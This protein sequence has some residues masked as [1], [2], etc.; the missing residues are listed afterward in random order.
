VRR[1]ERRRRCRDLF[2]APGRFPQGVVGG[3]SRCKA[4]QESL[5]RSNYQ[6]YSP[7]TLY[8]YKQ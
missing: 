6:S 2:K 7:V 8:L 5:D 3:R 4:L 1:P